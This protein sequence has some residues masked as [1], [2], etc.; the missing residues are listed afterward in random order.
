MWNPP[1]IKYLEILERNDK[2]SIYELVGIFKKVREIL[3][4]GGKINKKWH[5]CDLNLQL[6][7]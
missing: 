7:S 6:P 1:T 2:Q 3:W 5:P 4:G